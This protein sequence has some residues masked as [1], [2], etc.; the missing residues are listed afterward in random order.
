MPQLLYMKGMFYVPSKKSLVDLQQ[1]VRIL[2]VRSSPLTLKIYFMFCYVKLF[3]MNPI[4]ISKKWTRYCW[5]KHITTT[6]ELK[7]SDL[8]FPALYRRSKKRGLH[9]HYTREEA[10]RTNVGG[11]GPPHPDPLFLSPW[12]A[13]FSEPLTHWYKSL[14]S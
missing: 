11:V 1:F 14:I 9:T 10:R 2:D 5:Y 8:Y 3:S 6:D 7:K 13:L 4:Q 12:F